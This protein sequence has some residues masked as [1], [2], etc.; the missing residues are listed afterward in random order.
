[1]SSILKALKKVENDSPQQEIIPSFPQT[2]DTKKTVQRRAR[3]I[4]RL[5]RLLFVCLFMLILGGA[6]WFLLD[7]PDR[8]RRPS[9]S[10]H[11]GLESPPTAP[12][13]AVRIP[14]KSINRQE[15]EGPKALPPAVEIQPKPFPVDET[16]PPALF[17]EQPI[18]TS[19]GMA[20]KEEVSGPPGE[21]PIP[22]PEPVLS[23]PIDPLQFKLEAIVWANNPESRFA[24]I[25]GRIIRAGGSIDEVSVK[26]IGRDFVA[27][28]SGSETYRLKFTAE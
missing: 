22:S 5:H 25:N 1:M 27:I 23:K 28:E 3:G 15:T 24:V 20:E 13:A 4:Q 10:V 6:T 17:A 7:N 2:I 12:R 18:Q 21:M 14:P 26:E 11:A 19:T 9:E 16:P 8:F